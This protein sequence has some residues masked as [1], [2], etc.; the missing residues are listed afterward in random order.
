[1]QWDGLVSVA[2]KRRI[3][4]ITIDS[5]LTDMNVGVTAGPEILR[6]SVSII[7]PSIGDGIKF[8]RSVVTIVLE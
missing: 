8:E 4:A 1:L 2:P 3:D 6:I 7:P 5:T